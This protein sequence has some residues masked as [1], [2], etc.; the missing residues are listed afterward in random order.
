MCKI[1]GWVCPSTYLELR[2]QITWTILSL[3]FSRFVHLGRFQQDGY[4]KVLSMW[5]KPANLGKILF[6]DFPYFLIFWAFTIVP[7]VM[8]IV[9]CVP[10]MAQMAEINIDTLI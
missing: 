8:A 4:S 5:T 10:L 1:Q 9:K 3:R 2:Q 6:H 7:A